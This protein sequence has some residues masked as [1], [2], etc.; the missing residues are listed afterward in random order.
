MKHK[1][2]IVGASGYTGMEVVKLLER[3][4]E[5]ELVAASSNRNAGKP[6]SFIMGPNAPKMDFC[7]IDSEEVSSANVIFSCLPHCTAMERVKDWR[8]AGKI[9]IDLSADFRFKNPADYE[10]WYG[11]PHTAPELL[12]EA[13][14]GLPE[15]N[16]E[17]LKQADLIACPGCYPTVAVL[18]LLPAVKKGLVETD[19]IVNA[20]SGVTGA[21]R[22]AKAEYSFSE[23]NESMHG[24]GT[25]SH[26]HTPEMEQVLSDAAGSK[27]KVSFVPHLGTFNRGIYAT[28]YA[29]LKRD[30]SQADAEKLYNSFYE[31]EPFVT[32][33]DENPRLRHVQET[34]YC[35]LRPVVDSRA[36][37]LIIFGAID[38]LIKGAAGQAVQCFNI[39]FAHDEALGL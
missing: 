8:R 20:V 4:P 36:G 2:A 31:N 30:L 13:V 16:R 28:L 9:V 17:A 32:L 21:G 1:T 6:L 5:V 23:L 34:N 12:A 33:C 7:R 14:Y 15:I 37:R 29:R 35:H 19:L 27:V 11:K 38:N 18:G 25:P 26:R 39:R 22:Q 10:E 3:H 24:Y